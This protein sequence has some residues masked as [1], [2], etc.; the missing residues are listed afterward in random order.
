[1]AIPSKEDFEVI[2]H[3]AFDTGNPN[4]LQKYEPTKESCYEFAS[5]MYEKRTQLLEDL[6]VSVG[7][8]WLIKQLSWKHVLKSLFKGGDKEPLSK[9]DYISKLMS[10]LDSSYQIFTPEEYERYMHNELKDKSVSE[11]IQK[12]YGQSE[13]NEIPYPIMTLEEFNSHSNRLGNFKAVLYSIRHHLLNRELEVKILMHFRDYF[14]DDDEEYV[15]AASTL[16]TGSNLEPYQKKSTMLRNAYTGIKHLGIYLE[17]ESHLCEYFDDEGEDKKKY[18]DLLF[19][20]QELKKDVERNFHW[21]QIE[22]YL[23]ES[24]DPLVKRTGGTDKE[25]ILSFHLWLAIR[26]YCQS[27]PVEAILY[28]LQME[29]LHNAPDERTVHRWLQSWEERIQQLND[30]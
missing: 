1:M 7:Y 30:T 20:L 6:H 2:R 19:Q 5:L 25:R 23:S 13:E 26:G 15:Q 21:A 24:R 22:L 3:L 11:R 29:G 28:L 9:E 18:I 16:G 17:S 27:R 8:T 14:H 12:L 4:D 10:I